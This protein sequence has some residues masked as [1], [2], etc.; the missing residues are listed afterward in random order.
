MQYRSLRLR[1]FLGS[2]VVLLAACSSSDRSTGSASA[3][4]ATPVPEPELVTTVAHRDARFGTPTFTWLH[5]NAS[6]VGASFA[7]P[8]RAALATLSGL[9]RPLGL[10]PRAIAAAGEPEVEERASAKVARFRQRIGGTDIFRAGLT[11]ALRKDLEPVAASGFLAPTLA[12]SERPFI[13]GAQSAGAIAVRRA[14]PN[15]APLTPAGAL[16]EYERFHA[17]GLAEPARVKRVYFPVA[18]GGAPTLEPGYYV[19]VLVAQGA[20]RSYVVSALDGRVL[21][22]NDL[23][24]F[25]NFNYRV[26]ADSETLIPLD[27]PQGNGFAPHP[28]GKPDHMKLTFVDAQL[29]S[30]TNFP[31]SKND[32]WLAESATRTEG[33]NVFAYADVADPTGFDPGDVSTVTSGAHAFD[34]HYDTGASPGASLASERASITHLFYVT[35]FM[36]DWFYDSGFDEKS[37]NHQTDNLGRGGKAFDPLLAEAQDYDGRNNANATVPADG[38]SPR[39]QMYIFSGSSTGEL[40]VISPASIAGKKVVGT[41]GGFGKDLFDLTGT[42]VLGVDDG[43]AD[44]N[45]GC[46]PLSSVAGK[47]VLLHR[48]TCSFAQKAQNAQTAGAIGA[49]ITNTAK[50]S[51]PNNAPFMGGTAQGITIPVLSLS[52]PDGQA[53][54]GAIPQAPSVTM[55]RSGGV[56]V[57]GSLD[58]SIV[59]HEWGHVMSGRLVGDGNGQNTNQASGLSEGWSDFTALLLT[60]RADDPGNFGGAYTNGSYAMSGGG[61]DI[62]FGTRRVPYSI[63]MSKDP[64]TFKHIQNGVALPS[65]QAPISFGEDGSFNAEAH[66]TGEVWATMLFE[67]YVAL[68]HDGRYTFTQAQERMKRYLVASLKLTPVDPTLLEARD[69]VLAAAMAEDAKDATLFWQAFAKRGAGAGAEGPGK[70]STNNVGVKESFNAGNSAIVTGAVLRDDG[71]SCDHDGIIDEGEVATIELTVKNAGAGELTEAKAQLTSKTAGVSLLDA[72]LVPIAPLKPFATTTIKVKTSMRATAPLDVVDIDVNI[73]DPSFPASQPVLVT[74]PARYQADEAEASSATDNVETSHTAWKGSTIG[75]KDVKWNRI[76]EGANHYWSVG[77]GTQSADNNLQSPQFTID[78]T[79][80][81]VSWKHRWAF[82]HSQRRNTDQDGGV[83]EISVDNAKTWND[84]SQYGTID[85]NTTLDP[86][87]RG[88]NPLKGR[89]A[90]G[91]KSG[92]YPDKWIVSKVDVTLP[93]HPDSVRIR[94]RAGNGDTFSSTADGWDVDDIALGGISNTPFWSFVPQQDNCDPNGPS[95]NAGPGKTVH[96]YETVHV[97]GSGTHPQDKPLTFLWRQVTGPAVTLKDDA[98]PTPTFAAPE[99]PNKVAFELRAHDGAL[100]SAASKVEFNV[101]PADAPPK[102]SDDGG[103]SCRTA[104]TSRGSAPTPWALASLAALALIRR[105]PRQGSRSPIK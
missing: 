13:L 36:H 67:C 1:S 35:N 23:R 6:K 85:Y 12:G 3:A 4:T 25:E 9:A 53:L 77:D 62:Y 14:M 10:E 69:A 56:D 60:M 8:R 70:D 86:Q 40:D 88:E 41:A 97:E 52:A 66:N 80:F 79:T 64:F 99:A 38:S 11:V 63:D 30:L 103:C 28:T 91:N 47:I 31:F 5:T 93:T 17:A 78:G 90:Y 76:A 27:G 37:G 89:K 18:A 32:P 94:F 20:A 96:A 24:R 46:E 50:S 84:I 74:V 105:R 33:N 58:T 22:E 87:S 72:T 45:D 100:L 104:G 42:V 92:G 61:D 98:S 59:S 65:D 43:G 51:Q 29:V 71:I 95:V 83:V 102:G 57:D 101:V 21:F 34:F 19:E 54:E 55:K 44:P 81:S 2:A 16:G 49:I 48:D 82:R 68:L 73:V 75:P 26:W 15:G 7:T 39:L